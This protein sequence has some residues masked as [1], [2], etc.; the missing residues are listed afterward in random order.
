MLR[1][2]TIR[3]LTMGLLHFPQELLSSGIAWC[4]RDIAER[5]PA[6]VR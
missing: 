2:S 3:A 5:G 4:Y 1:P 6:G